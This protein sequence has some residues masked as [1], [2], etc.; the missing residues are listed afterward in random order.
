MAEPK[1]RLNWLK[2]GLRAM[3]TV[4]ILAAIFRLL[5]LRQMWQSMSSVGW[6]LWLLVL[7]AF[8]AG[9]LVAAYKW[10]ILVRAACA[11]VP[12]FEAVK[13]HGAGLF[14]NTWL[15]SI[16][17][18]D[19]VRAG[20][21][22]R[23]RGYATP[24]MAG[25]A[26]RALDLTALLLL[27]AVGLVLTGTNGGDRLAEVWL[28]AALGLTALVAVALLGHRW[29]ARGSGPQALRD[30]LGK[31]LPAISALRSLPRRSLAALGL[32]V[33]VQALFISL[34]FAIG[35]VMGIHIPFAV[36]LL[37]W[38]LAKIVALAPVSLGGLGVREA[39]LAGLLAPFGVTATLAV[40][41]A[42]VWQS[43]VFGL[44]LLCGLSLAPIWRNLRYRESAAR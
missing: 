38:P 28:F 9:H 17:G 44:G 39:A 41:Q 26:D 30:R 14:A 1:A 16:V 7:A 20:W 35:N 43:V 40:G 31:I 13:A 32:S 4:T 29:L 37:A 33:M 6:P 11:R 15:P 34:N 24:L 18:G 19:L 5:P 23:S 10:W 8:A 3:V 36:W 12:Y 22:G 21:L 27:A 2:L 25:M 42:L